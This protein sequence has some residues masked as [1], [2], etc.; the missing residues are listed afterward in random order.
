LGNDKTKEINPTFFSSFVNRNKLI[1][2]F[3]I[4]SDELNNSSE[5]FGAIYNRLALKDLK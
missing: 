1:E 5:I 4:T 3:K 2:E